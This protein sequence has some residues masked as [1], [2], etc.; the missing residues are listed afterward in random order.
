MTWSEILGEA[1]KKL[2]LAIAKVAVFILWVVLTGIQVIL[3][4]LIA[5]MRKFLF[6]NKK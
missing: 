4:E 3:R 6:P 2:L 5:S 1:V